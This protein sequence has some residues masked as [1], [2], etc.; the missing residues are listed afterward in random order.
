MSVKATLL[1]IQLQY[2]A[3]ASEGR[4]PTPRELAAV[5]ERHFPALESGRKKYWRGMGQFVGSAL[6]GFVPDP[7]RWDPPD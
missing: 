6:D 2:E 5:M 1:D 3:A 7:K 4:E